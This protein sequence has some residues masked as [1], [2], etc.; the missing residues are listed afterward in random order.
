MYILQ[1]CVFSLNRKFIKLRL[2]DEVVHLVS[3]VYDIIVDGHNITFSFYNKY[4]SYK[5]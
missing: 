4:D 2:H 1:G 5:N 3:L